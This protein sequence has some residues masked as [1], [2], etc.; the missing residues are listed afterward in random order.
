MAFDKSVK[1]RIAGVTNQ[2]TTLDALNALGDST[3]NAFT[4][5]VNP[6]RASRF[7]D[8]CA[9]VMTGI[10]VAGMATGGSYTV[11]LYTNAI[12]G[13][14][15]LPVASLTGIGPNSPKSLVMTNSHQAKC[16]PLPT[17]FLV[18]QTAAGGGLWFQLHAN[19]KQYRGTLSNSGSRSSERV[20][21]GTMMNSEK[22][23]ATNDNDINSSST[24]TLSATGASGSYAGL[25]KMDIWDNAVY[26]VVAGETI[27][28]THDVTMVGTIGG[29]TFPIATTGTGGALNVAGEKLA[30]ASNVYG[31]SPKPTA[32]LWTVASAGGTSS[33]RVVVAAKSGRGSNVTRG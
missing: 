9:F 7:W 27:S 12:A 1:A 30:L 5:I 2:N 17:H 21:E 22:V 8:T 13:Y 15:G 16:A 10:S 25:D 24:F 23:L 18:T 4:A 31:C 3:G 11:T 20:L 14:T 28:G 19:A 32:I 29:V 26:W 33:A 6:L